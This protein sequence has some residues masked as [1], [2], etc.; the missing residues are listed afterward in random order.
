VPFSKQHA[1]IACNFFELV[2]K[3]T[4]DEWWG[5]PFKLAPWQEETLS[6]VFGQRDDSG[7][8]LIQMAYLEIPKKSGKSELAAG[9]VLLALILD[10]NPGAQ[11][12]GAAAGQRQAMNVYRAACKMVEQSPIL[13]AELRVLRGTNRIMKRKDPDSFYA[14]IAGDGDMTDGVNPSFVVV[15]EVHRWRTR[16]QIENW[17]VLSKGGITRKQ[18][19][20]VGI[21]TAGVVNESPLAWRLHEKTKRISEGVI[22]DPTFYGKIYGAEKEDDWT[23]EKTWI[24]A[25]PS[26]KENG[27]FLDISKYREQYESTQGDPTAQASFKRYFLNIWDQKV[28]RAIDMAKWDACPMPWIA[29]GLLAKQPEDKVRP[30]PKAILAHFIGPLEGPP[31]RCWAGV[32]LSMTTDLSAVAFVFPYD[33]G[34]GYDVLPFFWMPEDGVRDREK[35]DG[36]PYRAWADLGFIELSPGGA[37][38]YR[39]V[40]ARLKWGAEMFDLQEICFDRYN[41]REMSTSLIDEGYKCCEIIQGFESLT[42]PSKKLLELIV[43]GKLR[44]G[45]HPVLR[46]N[47]FCLASVEKNDNLKFEKPER[48]KNSSRID[49]ISAIVDALARALVAPPKYRKSIFDSGPVKFS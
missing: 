8:R 15:D 13:K 42:E 22:Q 23:D 32:D 2:L 41:S 28:Q 39:D 29:A 19:L 47:A 12:Y 35:R 9:L 36:M 46:W 11:V 17:D 25:N 40:K 20:T 37:I 21:T 6:R 5:Q 38:D 44:H 7:N 1:D 34:Q 48:S 33:D 43:T 30:L 31:R 26:L 24:K 16:K 49:G 3:H 4:A 10:P 14:A 45:A 27:G 18:A